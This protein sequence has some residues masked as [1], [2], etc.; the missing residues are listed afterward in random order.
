MC[1]LRVPVDRTVRVYDWMADHLQP[2]STLPKFTGFPINV[3][4][5]PHLARILLRD[6]NSEL[7]MIVAAGDTWT[8]WNKLARST[9]ER[10]DIQSIC[11]QSPNMIFAF[12]RNSRSLKQYELA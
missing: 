11:I 9:T 1:T 4:L 8:R 2:V 5:D 10:L 12:D 7:H 3:V 6:D